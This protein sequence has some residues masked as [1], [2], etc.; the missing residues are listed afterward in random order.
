[1]LIKLIKGL[2]LKLFFLSVFLLFAVSIKAAEVPK[3][4]AWVIDETKTLSKQQINSISEKLAHHEQNTSDQ[5][6]VLIIKTLGSESI[7]KYAI[8]VFNEWQL[9]QPDKKNGLLIVIAK[10]DHKLRIEVGNDLKN[11]IT[12][13]VVKKI[14]KRNIT[15]LINQNDY[16][17]AIDITV[18]KLISKTTVSHANIKTLIPNWPISLALICSLFAL[19]IPFSLYFLST[20]F[21][22]KQ[23]TLKKCYHIYFIPSIALSLI[24]LNLFG[25]SIKSNTVTLIYCLTITLTSYINA[26]VLIFIVCY[27]KKII[28]KAS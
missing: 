1:M 5:F 23:L 19:I 6:V 11:K 22:K 26:G 9:G 12:D 7:D 15:P 14:I 20:R 13:P 2:H 27:I 3:L 17:H 24:L 21:F 25:S 10:D 16:Y 28:K 8:K 4:N 18:D